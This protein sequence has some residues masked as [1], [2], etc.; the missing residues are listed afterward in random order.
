MKYYDLFNG[1]ADGLIS[2]H[3]YRMFFPK[4][5][6]PISGVK[7]D[8]KLL[9]HMLDVKNSNITVFDVSHRSNMDYV[10]PILA[11]GNKITW[12]DHHE[13]DYYITTSNFRMNLDTDPSCCTSWLVDQY[14][15]GAHRPWTIAG[16]Y[17]DNLDQLVERINPAFSQQTLD[18]LKEVGQTLNY[19]GYGYEIT[20]LTVDPVD[21]YNDMKQYESPFKY[22]MQSETF[23][24]IREQMLQDQRD[25]N[26]S[27]IMYDDTHC[28]VVLLPETKAA[29]RYSGIYSNQ[30]TTDNPDKAFAVLTRVEGGYRIS[31]RAPKN[32]PTG[33]S[34]IALQFPSGGGREKAAGINLLPLKDY[35]TFL[36]KFIQQYSIY[37][38]TD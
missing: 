3:Q 29:I 8:V 6:K 5:S 37:P 10:E 2:L 20:D 22:Y 28:Q 15:D 17:G 16:A 27:E 36:S 1:D 4:N 21:V 18:I 13:A 26:S 24:T 31:I 12:F 33:A 30:L 35:D 7:R 19:N 23:T 9:R 25:L 14:I 11:K 32:A 38:V 34:G